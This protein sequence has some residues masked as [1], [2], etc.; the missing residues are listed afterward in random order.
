MSDDATKWPT[1][2]ATDAHELAQ[3]MLKLP[4]PE[5]TI[6]RVCEIEIKKEEC[7]HGQYE[8]LL[9]L[10]HHT[11]FLQCLN[12]LKDQLKEFREKNEAAQKRIIELEIDRRSYWASKRFNPE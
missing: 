4:T 9:H 11:S 5:P 8:Y 6:C 1:I 12:N 2:N 10:G 7:D 3:V